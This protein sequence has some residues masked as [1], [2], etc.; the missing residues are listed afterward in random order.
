MYTRWE[1]V[2]LTTDLEW[3][4]ALARTLHANG[5][6]FAYA[7]SIRECK[8]IVARES[9]G[10]IFWDSHSATS[11]YQE[12][13]QA[14]RS[15]DQSVKIV[16]I[17]HVDDLRLPTAWTGAFGVIPFPG[18]PTDIEWVLSRALRAEFQNTMAGRHRQ[19]QPQL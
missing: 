17:S 7:N 11:T 13:A 16:I 14:V 18:Q 6:D 5:V 12:L 10:L 2:I 19:L 8:E 1:A 4:H 3:R 15:L 9:V